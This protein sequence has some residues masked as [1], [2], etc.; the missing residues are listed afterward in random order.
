MPIAYILINCDLGHEQEVIKQLSEIKD[1]KEVQGTYGVYD[2]MTRVVSDSMDSL[3]DTVTI[4]MTKIPR[5]RSKLTLIV[6]E[7]QG[8]S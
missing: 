1:V 2:I 4:G 7:G 3:R 6:I 8:N 5:I